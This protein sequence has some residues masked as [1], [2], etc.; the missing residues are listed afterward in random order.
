MNSNKIDIE[1][2]QIIPD[3]K[4]LEDILNI[5]SEEPNSWQIEIDNKYIT[6][7]KETKITILKKVYVKEIILSTFSPFRVELS[8]GEIDAKK[9][10]QGIVETDLCFSTIYYNEMGKIITIDFHKDYR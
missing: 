9:I 4:I 6:I 7:Q 10:E 3:T 5:L 1:I 8:L 2:E